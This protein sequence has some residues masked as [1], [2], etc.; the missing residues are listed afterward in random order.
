MKNKDNSNNF[1]IFSFKGCVLILFVLLLLI[2]IGAGITIAKT[3]L[4]H[5]PILS[6]AVYKPA[7][8]TRKVV[9]QSSGVV[10]EEEI[11][12]KSTPSTPKIKGFEYYSYQKQL[13][14]LLFFL[15]LQMGNLQHLFHLD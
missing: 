12:N 15:Q 1:S 2:G 3:G 10:I 8:P 11:F 6:N 4:L 13:H 9:T 7:Q 14:L 5:I